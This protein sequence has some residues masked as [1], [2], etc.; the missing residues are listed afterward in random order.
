MK[1][2]LKGAICLAAAMTLG[3][4]SFAADPADNSPPDSPGRKE[5]KSL[6]RDPA[7][8]ASAAA[9]A[10]TDTQRDSQ[11]MSFDQK[12]V[13]HAT[14][15]GMAE[16]AMAKLALERAQGDDVKAFARHMVE[17]HTKANEQLAQFAKD[18]GIE[19][20]TQT[21]AVHQACMQMLQKASGRDFD[22][23]YIYDQVADHVKAVLWFRDAS[24][25]LKDQQL[26]QFA[27]ATYPTLTQHLQEA[28]R[29]AGMGNNEAAPAAG[30]IRGSG[31]HTTD[32]PAPSGPGN[33]NGA[34][35]T[36][37]TDTK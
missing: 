24:Q 23:A 3:Q 32:Q 21:D 37:G 27:V 30:H 19:V 12:F 20:P 11:H 7:P 10:A 26:R 25:E 22:R 34:A 4:S 31:S 1:S 28:E 2:Y 15:S 35:G 36:S 17:D 33:G 29:L 18:K 6:Q 9:D 8:A 13:K 14:E 5:N 16:V